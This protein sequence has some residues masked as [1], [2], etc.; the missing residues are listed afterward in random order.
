VVEGYEFFD[1]YDPAQELGGDYFDY[2]P[3]S[4]GRLAIALAD[5]SGKGIS[6]ALLMAKLSAEARYCLASEPTPAAAIARLNQVFCESRWED[7]FITLVVGVLDPKQH[8]VTLVSA[9]H[10]SPLL[11]RPSCEVEAVGE[12]AGGLPLGV[13][14]EWEYEEFRLTLGPGDSLLFCTD[15][16]TDAMNPAG[17]FY[18]NDRLLAQLRAPATGVRALGERLIESVRRHI[19]TRAQTDDMCVTYF[20]RLP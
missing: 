3:L 1:F 6:A 11:R 13:A 19:N 16:I 15:G 10:G 12:E 20:G 9:G 8:E 2:I 17:E 18:G 4:G 5:V 14:S 7:R